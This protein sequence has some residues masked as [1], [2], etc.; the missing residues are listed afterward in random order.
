MRGSGEAG[1][2]EQNK[3]NKEWP[4]REKGGSKVGRITKTDLE[5]VQL[6]TCEKVEGYGM[7]PTAWIR[8]KR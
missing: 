4:G 1:G 8:N 5:H 7:D 6:V 3:G 2:H